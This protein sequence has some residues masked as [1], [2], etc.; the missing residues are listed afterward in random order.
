MLRCVGCP[1]GAE[2]QSRSK[3]ALAFH[4]LWN[5]QAPRMPMACEI[6]YACLSGYVEGGLDPALGAAMSCHIQPQAGF[7]DCKDCRDALHERLARKVPRVKL[8]I[9][10]LDS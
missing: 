7:G 8:W 9:S 10:D 2:F 4:G 5:H 3:K 6:F 1:P